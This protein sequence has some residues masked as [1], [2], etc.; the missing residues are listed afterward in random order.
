MRAR[1]LRY[2]VTAFSAIVACAGLRRPQTVPFEVDPAGPNAYQRAR[3]RVA[4]L[5]EQLTFNQ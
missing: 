4:Q 1:G 5:V 3:E 2:G